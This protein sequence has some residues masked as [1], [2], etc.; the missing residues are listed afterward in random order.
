[1]KPMDSLFCYSFCN[2][3]GAKHLPTCIKNVK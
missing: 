3:F 1:M 2:E